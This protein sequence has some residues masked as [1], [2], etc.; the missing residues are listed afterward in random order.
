[1]NIYA[2]K[3]ED[4][5]LIKIDR[6]SQSLDSQLRRNRIKSKIHKEDKIRSLIGDLLSEYALKKY[7]DLDIKNS[8]IS[9]NKYGKPEIENSKNIHYNISHSSEY[10]VCA[11]SDVEIGIDIEKKREI[12]C[13]DISSRYFSVEEN[14]LIEGKTYKKSL[15]AF[16]KLWTLKESY[17]KCCGKGF[18]IPLHSFS[19]H[20]MALDEELAYGSYQFKSF[21]IKDSYH[22]SVCQNGKKI[23]N[24]IDV[25]QQS[26][27][28]EMFLK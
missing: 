11:V 25:I 20:T 10:V 26:E 15:D 27:L 9:L 18:S 1:M 17:I 23:K 3:I 2:V 4:I 16:Y 12:N 7:F 21:E 13:I 5:S 8:V 24:Y 22:I 19:L 28:I 6:L 14:G